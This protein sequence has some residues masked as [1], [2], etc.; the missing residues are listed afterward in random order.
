[1]NQSAPETAEQDDSQ[2]KRPRYYITHGPRSFTITG[3]NRTPVFV[4]MDDTSFHAVSGTSEMRTGL[5]EYRA[6][7]A[8]I[9][10]QVMAN[11]RSPKAGVSCYVPRWL[12][13][14]SAKAIN[15]RVHPEWRALLDQAN[16]KIVAVQK[17]IFA[18]TFAAAPVAT[19]REL[20]LNPYIVEDIIRFPAAAIAA[21]HVERLARDVPWVL[22]Q[23][24]DAARRAAAYNARW[25]HRHLSSEAAQEPEV[26]VNIWIPLLTKWRSLFS[27]TGDT[28][29]S[30]NKTLMNLP[31]RVTPWTL[32]EL[33][34][35][36]L[37]R[38]VTDR[39][40]VMLIGAFAERDKL[41]NQDVVLRAGRDDIQRAMAL[42]NGATRWH[43]SLS[44]TRSFSRLAGYLADFPEQHHGSIV[45]LARKTMEWHRE[46]Q[47]QRWEVEVA[48]LGGRDA[49]AMVP[50]IPLPELAGVRF[51]AAVGDILDEGKMMQH[52]VATYAG[53]AVAGRSYLFHVER[54]GEMATVEVGGSGRI[55]QAYGPRNALNAAASWGTKVLGQW[56]SGFPTPPPI[57]SCRARDEFDW[58]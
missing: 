25:P 34:R 24:P 10:T 27:S 53:E 44:R 31:G 51:L 33:W 43:L 7:V 19:A 6:L 56:A 58:A 35:V 18:A 21:R 52:C 29:T 49:P 2:A 50:P 9:A 47:E 40:E 17:A 1:M 26:N 20:Y 14:A 22:D 12:R 42:V 41:V 46:L 45:G 28:Y 15:A 4:E 55:L 39:A 57:T 11:W 5:F 3:E 16:P 37:P 32:C 48:D 30:L 23:Y 13:A 36:R 8:W 38:P 54:C